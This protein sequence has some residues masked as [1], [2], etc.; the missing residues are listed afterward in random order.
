M[1][2][3]VKCECRFWAATILIDE[4]DQNSRVLQK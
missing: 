2:I 4:E 3:I 1:E